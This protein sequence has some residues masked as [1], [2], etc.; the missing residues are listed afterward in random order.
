[1]T[2]PVGG[3][4]DTSSS[5]A[6]HTSGDTSNGASAESVPASQK[7]STPT[8]QP[9][10]TASDD[11]KS[12]ATKS[13]NDDP[14]SA[15]GDRAQADKKIS[16]IFNKSLVG[17]GGNTGSSSAKGHAATG[18][19]NSSGA[20]AAGA[21]GAANSGLGSGSG[22]SNVGVN[23]DY[24][25][26]PILKSL[27]ERFNAGL[28]RLGSGNASRLLRSLGKQIN[29]DEISKL[30]PHDAEQRTYDLSFLD[31]QL[32]CAVPVD[33]N[34]GETCLSA[35]KTRYG[36]VAKMAQSE[37]IHQCQMSMGYTPR[38]IASYGRK[39]SNISSAASSPAATGQNLSNLWESKAYALNQRFMDP[40]CGSLPFMKPG[41]PGANDLFTRS[42]AHPSCLVVN[43]SEEEAK[44]FINFSQAPTTDL[45]GD[46]MKTGFNPYSQQSWGELRSKGFGN[47][48][49]YQALND[50]LLRCPLSETNSVRSLLMQNMFERSAKTFF[51]A[52]C[53]MP[54]INAALAKKFEADPKTNVLSS[55]AALL[56]FLS[57]S[58]G[59]KLCSKIPPKDTDGGHDA[60]TTFLARLRADVFLDQSKKQNGFSE[61]FADTLAS[62]S[63]NQ[64]KTRE[65]AK[66]LRD[67]VENGTATLAQHAE[68]ERLVNNAGV[69][70][71]Q[72]QQ[73]TAQN[74]QSI[75]AG[76][77]KV[78][79]FSSQAMHAVGSYSKGLV[80]IHDGGKKTRT[81][82]TDSNTS[83][84]N[85]HPG[86]LFGQPDKCVN[87]PSL[88]PLKVNNDS[89]AAYAFVKN[90]MQKTHS[91]F[92]SEKSDESLSYLQSSAIALNQLTREGRC[93]PAQS[94][95]KL[96]AKLQLDE[97]SQFT[98]GS[99]VI[100]QFLSN[101]LDYSTVESST[102][103]P[104]KALQL[105]NARIGASSAQSA[106]PL[107]PGF[108]NRVR[109]RFG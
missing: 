39:D 47:G 98:V 60:Q 103:S 45:I 48:K 44:Q 7:A 93:V 108:S 16:D 37:N 76:V 84:V 5:S 94:A 36:S 28:A 80:G 74:E 77:T 30:S 15:I 40:V 52:G 51:R 92:A 106:K 68:F 107:R 61:N 75:A 59:T 56:A 91:Q 101:V 54:E 73:Q 104:L 96:C 25:S 34:K 9:S 22:T 11:K 65:H 41:K 23:L 43:G 46:Y 86:S 63:R 6:S 109:D 49:Q 85:V 27:Q 8:T 81:P 88:P 21:D 10:Q 4:S 31:D 58:T 69:V 13:N 32:D 50:V 99:K 71:L 66:F 90:L 67:K 42:K 95:Q 29:L 62:T 17:S 57:P 82:A 38:M 100:Y 26:N 14:L 105:T 78:Q 79:D 72:Q 87:G 33:Q 53:L 18:I 89:Q 12:T 97:K 102:V 64:D 24:A 3:N 55:D 83:G 35:I 2:G 70:R 19:S 20:V 1:M